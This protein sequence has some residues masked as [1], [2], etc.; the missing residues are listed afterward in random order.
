MDWL[1]GEYTGQCDQIWLKVSLGQFLEGLLSG[2]QNLRPTWAN[3]YAIGQM[4]IVV[5]GHI[6]VKIM[7]PSGHTGPSLEI[8]FVESIIM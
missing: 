8:P 5:N 2:W 1:K 6:L 3:Y 7:Y 4:S